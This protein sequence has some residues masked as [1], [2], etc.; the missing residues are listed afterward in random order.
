MDPDRRGKGGIVTEMMPKAMRELLQ[1]E[2]DRIQGDTVRLKLH[3]GDPGPDFTDNLVGGDGMPIDYTFGS[4]EVVEFTT[5]FRD[6]RSRWRRMLPWGQ[7]ST[8]GAVRKYTV[9][10]WAGGLPYRTQVVMLVSGGT[11]KIE[12]LDRLRVR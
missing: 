7:R 11:I 12:N 3:D 5:P 2:L 6:A 10:M 8:Q 1:Q 4:G 9:S